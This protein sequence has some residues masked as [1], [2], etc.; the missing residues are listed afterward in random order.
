MISL[1]AMPWLAL[2][3]VPM[4]PIY[5]NIQDRYRHSARDI[6]RLS[7]NAL[8]PLYA[9]FTETLQGL[10]IIRA[11]RAEG[12]FH[13]DFL[14]KLEESIRAQLTATAAQRWLGLRLKFL[15]AFLVGGAGFVA[16]VTS[17]HASNPELVGLAI[18]YAL[19]ITGLLSGLLS[20]L[21]E[22]EQELVAVERIDKYC[23]LRT[24]RNASGSTDPPI[25]WPCQG[26]IS[27]EDV[28][29]RYR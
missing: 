10:S 25:G 19:S 23:T 6:K 24:E 7:S 2:I 11:M 17:A 18:S 22:T 15:G 16:A 12:R 14:F 5:L 9:H 13:R 28:T 3:V 8:S 1:Y 29:L 21:A 4:T 26:V 27:F 20:A